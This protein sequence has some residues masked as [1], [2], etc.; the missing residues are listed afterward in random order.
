MRALVVLILIKLQE[1]TQKPVLYTFALADR[2]RPA[3]LCLPI[4]HSFYMYRWFTAVLICTQQTKTSYWKGDLQI[5][6]VC[7]FVKVRKR[8]N[9]I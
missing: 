5:V 7:L 8:K 4:V 1:N 9:I 6:M 3:D 2:C